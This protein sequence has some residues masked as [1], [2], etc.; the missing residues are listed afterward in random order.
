M[1][2]WFALWSGHVYLT[3]LVGTFLLG[4]YF[5]RNSLAS[6]GYQQMFWN[7][8]LAALALIITAIL[9]ILAQWHWK[10]HR[11]RFY[12]R[13]LWREQD[14]N[15]SGVPLPTGAWIDPA[16]EAHSAGEDAS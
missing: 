3:L 12:L 2:R 6:T 14:T 1:R 7:F 5:T 4:L 8:M 16:Y 9:G 13:R 15:A 10:G 11:E